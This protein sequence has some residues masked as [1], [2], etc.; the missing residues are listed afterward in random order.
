MEELLQVVN[1][2]SSSMSKR[3]YDE[4]LKMLNS[5]TYYSYLLRPE[6][7]GSDDNVFPIS[8]NTNEYFKFQFGKRIEV[9]RSLPV[10]WDGYGAICP[11]ED[12]LQ[13]L[14]KLFSILPNKFKEFLEEDAILPNPNGTVTL[15]WRKADDV[16]SVEIGKDLSNFYAIVADKIYTEDHIPNICSILPTPLANALSEMVA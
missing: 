5:Q 1:T 13:N 7:F 8:I 10:N 12:V 15:E 9:L 3:K 14:E 4:E 11:L 2:I 6:C 16:V